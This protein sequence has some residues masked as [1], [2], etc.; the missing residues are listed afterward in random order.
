MKQLLLPNTN[1]EV[2]SDSVF[3]YQLPLKDSVCLYKGDRVVVA[4]F[5]IHPADAV[6][7]VWVKLAHSEQIQGWIRQNELTDSFVP[8]DSISQFIHFFSNTYVPYFIG[9]VALFIL[10]SLYRLSRKR[11]LRIVFFHDIDSIY[12]TLFCLLTGVM[13]TLY[14]SL[15]LFQPEVWQRF[16]LYPALSPFGLPWLLSLFI[17]SIWI[18]LIVGIATTEEAFRY[19]PPGQAIVYLLGV[20]ATC[21]C[22]YFFFILTTHYYIGYLFLSLFIVYYLK[23]GIVVRHKYYCGHCGQK[24]KEKGACPACGAINE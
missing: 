17:S 20:G 3:L 16:Y 22:C 8:T 23:K 7:S 14:E 5:D 1:L 2:Y 12:P 18:L 10:I 21:V 9:I 15:Q 24:L 13:A 4:E 19:L 6:D 11:P